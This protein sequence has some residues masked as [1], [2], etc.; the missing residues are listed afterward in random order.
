[1]KRL[2]LVLLFA[3]VAAA[4]TADPG[5]LVYARRCAG[6]HGPGQMPIRSLKVISSEGFRSIVRKGVNSMPPFPEI[7]PRALSGVC[8]SS[9][10]G[11]RSRIAAAHGL[12][13]SVLGRGA[14]NLA[15]LE[16]YAPLSGVSKVDV[17]LLDRLSVQRIQV[18]A[19]C[20]PQEGA[21]HRRVELGPAVR[22][23]VLDRS[24]LGPPFLVGPVVC[25]CVEDIGDAVDVARVALGQVPGATTDE[26]AHD[27]LV[28]SGTTGESPTTSDAE[29]DMLLRAVLEAV[30]D[31]WTLLVIRDLLF[32]GKRRF[33][34]LLSSPEGIPT[35]I[36]S[37]RL[38]RL[39]EGG[40]VN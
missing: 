30:G 5:R 4:Q 34:E 12:R 33:G 13:G 11:I 39:E 17:R 36:L 7:T 2:L 38:R 21:D 10:P 1:M 23:D 29:K 26:Q 40:L 9:Q 35:N 15:I 25:Q 18:S 37:D 32:L 3:T 28:I 8:S 16:G 20:D 31:R 14:G 22:R 24:S 27:G 6:C 19:S